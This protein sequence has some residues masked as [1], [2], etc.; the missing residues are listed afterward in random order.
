MVSIV[1][2]TVIDAP[3]DEVWQVLRDFNGHDRWHP[4]VGESRIEDGLPSDM[5]GAVRQFRLKDGSILREQLLA[6]NDRDRSFTYCLLEAPLPLHDYVA[7]V[8]LR[9]VTQGGGTFWRWQSRF[10]PPAGEA[11]RLTRLVGEDI[12][13]AGFEAI[14]ALLAKPAVR[15][16]PVAPA[17]AVHEPSQREMRAVAARAIVLRSHG[18]PEVLRL[19]EIDLPP[20]G[21]GEIRLAQTAAGVNFIDVHGRAG[22]S[23]SLRSLPA[24]PGLEAA[25]LVIDVGAGVSDFQVGD[26]VAY[27]GGPPGAY[28][29]H[30]NL[31]AEVAVPL[32]DDIGDDVA[33]A[34][35]LRG[36][37][38][39]ALLTQVYPVG[40]D[41][42]L[43]V[44]SAAGGLGAIIGQW[45]RALGAHVIGTVSDAARYDAAMQA[46]DEVLV[47]G[48]DDIVARVQAMTNGRG[49]DAA[50]DGVGQ[51]TFATTIAALAPRGHLLLY[52]R[53]S[54]PVGAQDLEQLGQRSLTVS[55]P[56]FADYADTAKDRR[57]LAAAYFAM[58]R[59]GA[60]R[61]TID[62]RL[63][64]GEAAEAH[65]RLESGTVTGVC[66]LEIA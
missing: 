66:L 19:E 43:L 64:L 12:Y 15:R 50:F 29:S 8:S 14:R 1:R 36:M 23:G 3:V 20:P 62:T 59:A 10:N 32:P 52:G 13:R 33:A 9:P 61:V 60:V 2:S 48:R 42:W 54:G 27:A 38:A 65:R 6:L 35:L 31:P 26:R 47:R 25:G 53:V 55:R 40:P 16:E 11:E 58:L 5:V 18:G 37:T 56:N 45:A 63:P 39:A 4:Q 28:A 7:T 46:C 34:T 41:D 17:A 30:R 51:A 21:A 22:S 49:A 57:S 24:V 44:H